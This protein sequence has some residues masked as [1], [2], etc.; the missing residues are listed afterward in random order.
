MKFCL[1]TILYIYF[2][3][4]LGNILSIILRLGNNFFGN[5]LIGDGNGN[6]NNK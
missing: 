3:G 4:D 5:K 6:K 1:D 2:E